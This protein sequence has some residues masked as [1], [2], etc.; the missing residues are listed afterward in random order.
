MDYDQ[1][2]A[3]GLYTP[4]AYT[5]CKRLEFKNLLG[6][7]EN[8]AAATDTK[9]TENFRI[10]EEKKNSWIFKKAKKQKEI[11][12]WLITEPAVGSNTKKE[13]LLG[14]AVSVPD[15]ETVFYAL[16][17]EQEPE[18]QLS[19]FEEVKQTVDETAE[20]TAALQEL[21]SVKG[22]RIATF[23]VK[24]QYD[25]LDHSGTEQYFDIL[26]A[27]YLLN[28]LKMI[29]IRSPLLQSILGS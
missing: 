4:E 21:S 24:R 26:I 5:L 25:Y 9:I 3:E 1:A 23:D 15:V 6:R 2:K 19:L 11:G 29:M 17:R 27:A 28:P 13:E 7:F 8:N 14:A 12:L 20:I 22:L 18:G 16:K 10:I